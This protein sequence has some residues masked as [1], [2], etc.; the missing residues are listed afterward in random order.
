MFPAAGWI[1]TLELWWWKISYGSTIIGVTF[2][3]EPVISFSWIMLRPSWDVY[4]R[5]DGAIWVTAYVPVPMEYLWNIT[6]YS[7]LENLMSGSRFS[8]PTVYMLIG[9]S[10]PQKFKQ[11]AMMQQLG[12]YKQRFRPGNV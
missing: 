3:L 1:S 6:A 4:L 9:L 11:V 10:A 8:Q 7:F 5:R 12:F 2:L